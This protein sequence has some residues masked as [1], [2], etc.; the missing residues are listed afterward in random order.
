MSNLEQIEDLSLRREISKRF[1]STDTIVGLVAS[2][3]LSRVWEPDERD[4]RREVLNRPLVDAYNR[5][6]FNMHDVIVGDFNATWANMIGADMN[7]VFNNKQPN[8]KEVYH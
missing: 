3:H 5:Y 6:I 8:Y 2:C 7:G 4:P 1:L